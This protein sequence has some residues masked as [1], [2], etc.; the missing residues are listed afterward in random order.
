MGGRIPLLVLW[1]HF[2]ANLRLGLFPQLGFR[3]NAIS[4]LFW[5]I[6]EM[7]KREDSYKSIQNILNAA[8]A[9]AVAVL[10]FGLMV[11]SAIC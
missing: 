8:L 2:S 7:W 9:P 11:L 5:S 10:V 3:V 1:E 4:H 6:W